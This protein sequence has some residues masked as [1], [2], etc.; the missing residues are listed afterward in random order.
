MESLVYTYPGPMG[1][2]L[3]AQSWTAAINQVRKKIIELGTRSLTMTDRT[4]KKVVDRII[5]GFIWGSKMERIKQMTVSKQEKKGGKRVPDVIQ[6]I[7]VQGLMHTIK[8]I[9]A[10]ERKKP[11]FP[12]LTL[13]FDLPA[14][15]SSDPD[16]FHQP[17][18]RW[19][20]KECSFQQVKQE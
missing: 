12:V 10:L 9:K 1:S 15:G 16:D 19:W 20:F 3:G 5:Y 4:T 17:P 2:S 6:L 18:T 14:K 11:L 7:R 13:L 8:N